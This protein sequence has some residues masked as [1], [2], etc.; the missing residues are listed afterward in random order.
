M[1]PD[2]SLPHRPILR[3]PAIRTLRL[4]FV[5]LTDAAPLSSADADADAA[6]ADSG[7]GSSPKQPTKAW[8]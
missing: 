3:R 2:T 8:F 4:G 7:S 5:P 1:P 6:Q